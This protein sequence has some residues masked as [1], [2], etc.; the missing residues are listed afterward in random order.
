MKRILQRSPV[1]IKGA[2]ILETPYQRMLVED[3]LNK[4]QRKMDF[5]LRVDRVRNL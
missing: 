3:N 2:G 5:E 1:R 4:P